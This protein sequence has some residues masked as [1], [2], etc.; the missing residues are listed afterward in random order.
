M[1]DSKGWISIHR[2][3]K[4][5]SIW[6]SKEPFDRRSAWFDLLL[7][8]NHADAKI[9]VD[10]NLMLIKRGQMLTSSRK[11][12]EQ[13]KWSRGKVDR[14]LD[15]LQV[16]EMV[17]LERA[18]GR[19]AN[20]TILTIVNF[21]KY[22]NQRAINEAINDT[23]YDDI[24][25]PYTMPYTDTNNKNNKNNNENNVNKRHIFAPPS[26]VDVRD[27][28]LERGNNIDPEQFIAYYESNGWKVGKSPMKDWK[29]AIRNWEQRQKNDPKPKTETKPQPRTMMH[30][31][32]TRTDY[33]MKE[34][35]RMLLGR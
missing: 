35:E 31:M 7:S 19:T 13:W 11:L 29:A 24:D 12:A 30:Q 1:S 6:A 3:I 28:C 23:I 33:D 18:V 17:T 34:L 2:K 16:D 26:L 9:F 21:D 25:E 8:V 10:G 27:Y 15:V 32:E 4:D 14:F 5:S 20:G 22:Q